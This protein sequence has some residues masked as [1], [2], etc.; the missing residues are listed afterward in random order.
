MEMFDALERSGTRLEDGEI[1]YSDAFAGRLNPGVQASQDYLKSVTTVSTA[2]DE[3]S[4]ALMG[5]SRSMYTQENA[6]FENKKLP[7]NLTA[8]EVVESGG[9]QAVSYALQNTSDLVAQQ[10][11]VDSM[12]RDLVQDAAGDYG[13]AR[14]AGALARAEGPTTGP[15]ADILKSVLGQFQGA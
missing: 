14:L 7:E 12:K 4:D 2:T 13:Q 10:D 3:F 8:R 9:N 1:V 6:A 5:L 11:A 15:A